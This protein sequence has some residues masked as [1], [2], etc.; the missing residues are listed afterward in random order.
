MQLGLDKQLGDNWNL[1]VRLQRG[2]GDNISTTPN[3][4]RVDKEYVAIDTVEVYPDM[5]DLTDDAG[6]GGPDGIPDLTARADWGTG[7]N[8]CNVQ[9]YNPSP[10]ELM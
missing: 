1:Q 6:T 7:I 8:L 3:E 9:R 4:L 2:A 5:R 10:A